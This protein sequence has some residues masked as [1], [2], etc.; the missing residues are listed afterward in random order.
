MG[1]FPALSAE[2]RYIEVQ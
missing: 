2:N 1:C